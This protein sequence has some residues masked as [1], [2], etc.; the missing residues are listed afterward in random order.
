VASGGV[1]WL[2]FSLAMGWAVRILRIKMIAASR[3]RDLIILLVGGAVWLGIAKWVLER[4]GSALPRVA[5][6]R[7]KLI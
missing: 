5:M 1:V 2:I 4:S 3:P 6:R 7:L